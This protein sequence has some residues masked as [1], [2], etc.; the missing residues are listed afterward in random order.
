M[1]YSVIVRHHYFV[2]AY[3]LR[4]IRRRVFLPTEYVTRFISPL[5]GKKGDNLQ[6]ISFKG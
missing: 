2:G 6:N 5:L 1:P 4:G 3:C